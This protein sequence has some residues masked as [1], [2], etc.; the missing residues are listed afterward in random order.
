VRNFLYFVFEGGSLHLPLVRVGT[1]T[2]MHS[3]I[4][5][6]MVL[7]GGSLILPGM[8]LRSW[9]LLDWQKMSVLL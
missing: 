9:R 1:I 7:N 8:L 6:A 4:Q 2:I 5:L 3:S